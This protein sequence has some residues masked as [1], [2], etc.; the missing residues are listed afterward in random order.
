MSTH[1]FGIRHHGPGSTRSLLN[2]LYEL[3]PDIVLIEG[4]P[5]ADALI[6]LFADDDMTAPVAMLV[7]VP[8]EPKYASYYPFAEFSPEYQALKFA[9]DND[10]PAKFMD[11]PQRHVLRMRKDADLAAKEALETAQNTDSSPSLDSMPPTDN[12]DASE[13]QHLRSDP[14]GTLAKIAGYQDG[15]RWWEHFVE[16]QDNDIEIFQAL[17]E[18]MTALREAN[19]MLQNPMDEQREAYM[20]RIVRD[21]IKAG[22]ERIAIVCG[23]WH[24][25]A[26]ATMPTLKHDN[27]ILKGLKR[28]KVETTFT[29]WTHSRLTKWSGYGAGIWSPGWYQHRW[30]TPQADTAISWMSKVASL[31]REE[32]LDASPA[33]IIDAVRLAETVA[34]LRG[35]AV[36]GL[37]EF[38][39]ATLTVF[40]HG[41]AAPLRIIFNKLI[42]GEKMGTIPNDTPMMPLQHDFKHQKKRLRFRDDGQLTLDLR[43]PLHLER[44]HLLNRLILLGIHW[45][46]KVEVT[47]SKGTFKEVWDLSWQPEHTIKLIEKGSWGNT[48]LDATTAYAQHTAKSLRD[49]PQLTQLVHDVLLSD[50]PDAI[51]YVV[52]RLQAEAAA[53]GDIKELMMAFPALAEVMTYG[54]V[55]D[56]DAN[57]VREVVEGMVARTCIG[58]PTECAMLD[59]DAA[60]TMFQSIISFDNAVKLINQPAYSQ[61][62][63]AVLHLLMNQRG[64]HGLIRGRACRILLDDN[65]ID[66]QEAA[67]QMQIAMSLIGNLVDSAAWLEGFL[68]NSGFILVNDDRLLTII[69]EWLMGL[70]R[71]NFESLLPL[72]RRTVSSFEDGERRLIGRMIAGRANAIDT[73]LKIDEERAS[74]MLPI[75]SE[76][77]GIQLPD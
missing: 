70:D 37:E 55:R 52:H 11:L 73:T 2:A 22:Y 21:A 56:T 20:R 59:D 7:Y 34:T 51:A 62:W 71:D 24:A 57:M 5:D 42:V 69:D 4:P 64:V 47:Q 65:L 40:C 36:A 15:E 16:N 76:L 6:P 53:T 44:S 43:E 61:Q 72:L 33:Q 1:I 19:I 9:L 31:L 45:G 18:A 50:L 27:D 14:L 26:L 23:A 10:I 30:Q 68:Q 54:N 60:N 25:P 3:V 58:L 39:E 77:L 49:L 13:D 67:R 35:R 48:I 28:I 63:H 12:D 17:L 38:N 41:N 75:L 29:P 8:D 66:T 46:K 32:D 74:A